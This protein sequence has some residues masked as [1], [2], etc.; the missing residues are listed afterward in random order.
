MASGGG[1]RFR[2]RPPALGARTFSPEQAKGNAG[3]RR[4][5]LVDGGRRQTPCA[6]LRAAP[7]FRAHA[8]FARPP[9]PSGARAW[10]RHG[11]EPIVRPVNAA[12]RFLA[13]FLPAGSVLRDAAVAIT[14]PPRAA[15]PGAV[16][17]A[18][19]EGAI[20]LANAN[21]NVAAVLTMAAL[22]GE[23]AAEK[24][25]AVSE[26]PKAAFF[27]LHNA[28]CRSGVMRLHDGE[29]IDPTAII[30]PTAVLGRHVAVGPGVRI[31]A[32]AVLED[33]TIVGAETLIGPHAVIGGRG[34]QDTLVA[35]RN[36][37]VEFAGGVRIGERC[38]ILSGALIQ[39]PYL[40]AWTEIGD[41]AK[42]GPGA[43][44][45]HGCRV[46]RATYIGARAV[47]AGN[48]R[49]GDGVWIGPAAVLSDDL[50]IGDGA[51]VILG[52]VVLR[53][54][55]AGDVVSGNFALSHARH[56][57]IHTRHRHE[58]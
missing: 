2:L 17:Y 9:A 49:I 37:L 42:L 18:V 31:G 50:E 27:A 36:V 24:G 1:S 57:R 12:A 22:A 55:P 19:E 13:E 54:V 21:P 5:R 48:V 6:G 40:C 33:H 23:V 43:S 29:S 32:H 25:C 30:A 38:E 7:T 28:L 14:L 56:L 8:A 34:L 15:Q 44:V 10:A 3:V 45:G 4:A 46:G 51:R 58:R 11:V 53:S 26:Q 20:R 39:R 35:G 47:V 41:D 52:S 16:C